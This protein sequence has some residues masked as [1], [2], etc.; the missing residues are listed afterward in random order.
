[1][2]N[3]DSNMRVLLVLV[4]YPQ[5]ALAPRYDYERSS[6]CLF[7]TGAAKDL[8]DCVRTQYIT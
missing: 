3:R 8:S 2:P 6:V 5:G 1:M 7:V 4:L